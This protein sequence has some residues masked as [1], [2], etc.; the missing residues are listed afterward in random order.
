MKIE[1]NIGYT[2]LQTSNNYRRLLES[3]MIKIGLHY[4]QVSVLNLLWENNGMSQK[5]LSLKLDLSQPTI[6]KMVKSLLHNG[7]VS[8]S[9][10]E[11]DGRKMRVYLTDKGRDIE[12]DVTA[13]I[14]SVQTDFFAALTETERLILKQVLEKLSPE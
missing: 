3:E 1:S 6:N 9:Q 13:A 5:R 12:T 14:E 10:C 11:R 2:F 7:F 8:C 4:A